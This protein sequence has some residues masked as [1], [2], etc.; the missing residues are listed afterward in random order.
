VLHGRELSSEKS[1]LAEAERDHVM[2]RLK[3]LE[4]AL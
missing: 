3:A 2:R 4:K 1:D